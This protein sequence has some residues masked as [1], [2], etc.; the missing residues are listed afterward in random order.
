MLATWAFSMFKGE[1][2]TLNP[3]DRQEP[4]RLN[5]MRPFNGNQ[6]RANGSTFPLTRQAAGSRST[7][8]KNDQKPRKVIAVP[9]TRWIEFIAAKI[10][11]NRRIRSGQRHKQKRNYNPLWRYDAFV[12]ASVCVCG[13][14]DYPGTGQTGFAIH[15]RLQ[16]EREGDEST[17]RIQSFVVRP[18]AGRL[19]NQLRFKSMSNVTKRME[20]IPFGRYTSS[21]ERSFNMES[22]PVLTRRGN[23]T[24]EKKNGRSNSSTGGQLTRRR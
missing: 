22:S 13:F 7:P 4:V 9:C 11:P 18:R 19:I 16:P 10:Q 2:K 6:R 8:Q 5:L 20:I 21:T 14:E 3:I 12:C 23:Q 15:E 24:S 1:K 17:R